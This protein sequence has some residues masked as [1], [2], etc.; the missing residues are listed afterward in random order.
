MP[1]RVLAVGVEVDGAAATPFSALASSRPPVSN[2]ASMEGVF[3]SNRLRCNISTT[4]CQ[5]R[6]TACVV[7]DVLPHDYKERIA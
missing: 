6:H 1:S 2:S 3:I 7:C 5:F 4:S